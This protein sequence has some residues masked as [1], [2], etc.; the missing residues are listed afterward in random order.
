[1]S[2]DQLQIRVYHTDA[3]GVVMANGE[4]DLSTASLLEQA[5]TDGADLA[6]ETGSATVVVDLSGVTFMDSA[7]LRVL[8]AASEMDGTTLRLA[9]INQQLIRLLHLS[10]L[11]KILD[12]RPSL[13]AALT[14]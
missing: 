11:T 3:A 14:G 10:G 12:I 8:V 9:S 1:M 13:D 2:D 5:I 7:G 4:V 6:A